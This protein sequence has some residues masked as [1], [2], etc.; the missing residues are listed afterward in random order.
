MKNGNILSNTF[1]VISVNDIYFD[2]EIVV[3]NNIIPNSIINKS[4]KNN[5]K[6]I[7]QQ[8]SDE[9]YDLINDCNYMNINT[10]YVDKNN[11][12]KVKKVRKIIKNKR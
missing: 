9:V 2:D 12:K 11:N 5:N 7:E 3:N 4:K 8:M 10:Y 1:R 6:N